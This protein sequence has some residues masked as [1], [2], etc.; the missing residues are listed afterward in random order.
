MSNWNNRHKNNAT[1]H[2]Q[3]PKFS[4]IKYGK[5][6]PQ[7]SGAR[8]AVDEMSIGEAYLKIGYRQHLYSEESLAEAEQYLLR[9]REWILDEEDRRQ[10]EAYAR[11]TFQPKYEE[12]RGRIEAIGWGLSVEDEC[13][14]VE[15][16]GL[17][18]NR[19]GQG[20]RTSSYRFDSEAFE[21]LY[22]SISAEENRIA[23]EE[24]RS[25]NTERI[26]GLLSETGLPEDLWFLFDD[27]EDLDSDILK[28]AKA[29]LA[30][31]SAEKD[32]MDMHELRNC[33]YDRRCGAIRRVLARVG[34]GHAKIDIGSQANSVKLAYYIAG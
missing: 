9:M 24:R 16:R 15:K 3:V 18:V 33:G 2:K 23:E 21:E 1:N 10:A 14:R 12:L 22:E 8:Y 30:A 11:K 17:R 25:R 6:K 26:H 5:E 7:K 31:R 27:S 34:G 28:E 29:I 19:Y 32:S 20:S 13:A 4:F